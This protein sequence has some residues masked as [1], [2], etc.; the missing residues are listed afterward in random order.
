MKQRTKR[1]QHKEDFDQ[2]YMRALYH[3]AYEKAAKGYPWQHAL[4][5]FVSKRQ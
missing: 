2:V 3:Y 5:G 1:I 4:P